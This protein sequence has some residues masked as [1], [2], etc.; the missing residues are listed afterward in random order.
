MVVV[1]MTLVFQVRLFPLVFKLSNA[2]VEL[3]EKKMK[4]KDLLPA[5]LGPME[6]IQPANAWQLIRHA[7]LNVGASIVKIQMDKGLHW[8]SEK[9]HYMI[10]KKSTLVK[11]ISFIIES[12]QNKEAGQSL[13]TYYLLIYH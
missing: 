9:E 10:G 7:L 1:I 2:D 6:G 5:I 13:K 11:R 3:T 12:T 4:K 8:E